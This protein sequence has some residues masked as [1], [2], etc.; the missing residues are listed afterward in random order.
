MRRSP[1]RSFEMPLARA[2]FDKLRSFPSAFGASRTISAPRAV[3]PRARPRRS[4]WAS[5]IGCLPFYD[6]TS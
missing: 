4:A 6:S 1:P 3:A 5:F 2:L